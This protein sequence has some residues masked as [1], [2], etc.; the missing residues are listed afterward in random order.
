MPAP[1]GQAAPPA[2]LAI[3][4]HPDD[5]EFMMS[6]TLI[7]LGQA[8]WAM[9][10]MHLADGRCGSAGG[11]ADETVANRVAEARQA[12]ELIGAH[13]HAGFARD[14]EV[15]HTTEA[16]GR[17]LAV[18]R[19]V[20]PRV[21]LLH[22]PDDYMEDHVNACRIGVTAAFARGMANFPAIPQ[23]PPIA[24][25]VTIYHALPYGLRDPL[26]KLVRAG[27][28]VDVSEVI[29]RKR[30]MLA[31]HASQRR[32][33]ESSQGVDYLEMMATL[34]RQVGRM[35]GRFEVAEGWRRRNFLGFSADD[36]DPLA[37]A[38]GR[39]CLVDEEFEAARG[40]L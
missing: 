17:V 16:V 21:L 11:G 37:E 3:A 19:R 10:C 40:A 20:R 13:Y 39:R 34:C 32:W 7:L 2:A 15:Y 35:S 9:H 31:A 5:V 24:G 12:C 33:L 8:G 1:G 26:R 22:A 23:T 30:A 14:L 6:G 29:D 25:D 4:A 28:Y 38:L 27:L 18:I 36:G